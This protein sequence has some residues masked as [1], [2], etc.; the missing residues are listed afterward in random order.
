[1]SGSDSVS[2]ALGTCHWIL[3]YIAKMVTSIMKET[4]V[5]IVIVTTVRSSR[6]EVFCKKGVLNNFSKFTGKHLCWSL[7]LIACNVIKKRLQHRWFPMN[8]AKFLRAPIL[9]NIC[10]Q[11]LRKRYCFLKIF[12]SKVK[13]VNEIL[14][15]K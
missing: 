13:P 7:F 12:L 9:K 1:M 2:K 6:L 15:T 3:L 8:I 14:L 11:L 10:E 5:M 4:I